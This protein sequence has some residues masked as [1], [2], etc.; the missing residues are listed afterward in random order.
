MVF[1]L[2]L[3]FCFCFVLFV[4]V[5]CGSRL[6]C[7]DFVRNFELFLEATYLHLIALTF[8][9]YSICVLLV[10]TSCNVE[11]DIYNK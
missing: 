5:F 6:V 3:S 9:Y 7:N 10:F 2:M 8:V 1:L 11:F 4:C